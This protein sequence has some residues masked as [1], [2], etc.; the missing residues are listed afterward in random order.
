[1]KIDTTIKVELTQEEVQILSKAENLLNTIISEMDVYH[2]S[3]LD[4]QYDTFTKACL[5][6]LAT[7]L[8]SLTTVYGAM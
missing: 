3:N 4:T 6:E 1:M 5:D 8:N 2:I 7:N